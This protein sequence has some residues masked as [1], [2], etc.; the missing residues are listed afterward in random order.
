MIDPKDLQNLLGSVQDQ[1]KNLDTQAKEN[2][3]ESNSGGGLVK[4]K[5]NG[6]GEL[7]DIEID[8]ELLED[9]QTL[10]ILLIS[11]INDGYSKIEEE[12]KNNIF[13]KVKNIDITDIAKFFK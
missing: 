1:L 5:F 2:I 9:K 7:V 10:Q 4:T 3:I 11:A 13:D 6:S 8:D 12:K